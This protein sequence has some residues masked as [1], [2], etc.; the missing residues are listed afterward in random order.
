[1]PLFS[2]E[3]PTTDSIAVTIIPICYLVVNHEEKPKE[4]K[5]VGQQQLRANKTETVGRSLLSP[6]GTGS[7]N[8]NR[9]WIRLLQRCLI[10]ASEKRNDS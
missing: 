3:N 2:S 10:E 6:S 1:M 4:K 9:M 5:T 7:E 8:E